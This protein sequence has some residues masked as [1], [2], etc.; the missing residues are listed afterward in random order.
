MSAAPMPVF[1]IKAQDALA[2]EAVS[3]YHDLCVKY[4]LHG[5]AYQVRL[6]LAEIAD[7]QAANVDLIKLPDHDHVPAAAS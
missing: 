3:A 1:T 2:P 7:W 6:A 5:Q 4:G